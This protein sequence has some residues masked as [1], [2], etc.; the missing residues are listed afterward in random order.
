LTNISLAYFT[1]LIDTHSTMMQTLLLLHAEYYENLNV[2][3]EPE[4]GHE[5]ESDQE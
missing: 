3:Y 5:Y 1:E 2:K 4:E